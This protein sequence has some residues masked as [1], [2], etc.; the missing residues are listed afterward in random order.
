[1][2][3]W[4]WKGFHLITHSHVRFVS[5][6]V[7][8]RAKEI[9]ELLS[10]LDKVRQERRKAKANRNKYIGTGNDSMSFSSSG[11][12]YGGFGSDT[13]DYG[14]N[15][16]SGYGGSSGEHTGV[17]FPKEDFDIL[18]TGGFS[19]GFRD[20]SRKQDFEEYDAGEWEDAPRRSTPT[21]PPAGGSGSNRTTATATATTT[22]PAAKPEPKAPKPPKVQNLLDFDDDWGPSASA[23]APA[24]APA[25]TPAAA[26]PKPAASND[27]ES[28]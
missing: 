9:V 14:G 11:G 7:R 19:G 17:V 10:D 20:S 4:V 15:G 2:V 28:C 13:L 5:F 3:G 12:R 6:L 26:A 21:S 22:Q 23:P 16:S 1:M 18:A 25:P 8:Q 27:C 24:P